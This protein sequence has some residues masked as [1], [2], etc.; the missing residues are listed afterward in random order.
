MQPSSK[1]REKPIPRRG[2]RPARW[3]FVEVL[4]ILCSVLMI[5]FPLYAEALRWTE[6]SLAPAQEQTQIGRAHV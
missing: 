6:P 4:L 3:T 2:R 1:R 5:V